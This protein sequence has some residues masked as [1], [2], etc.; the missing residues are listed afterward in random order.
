MTAISAQDTAVARR[1]VL[2]R[3]LRLA[4][5]DLR[6]GIAGFY[7][8]V[9]CIA[10]GVG[11]IAAV[12]SLAQAFESTLANEGAV[13]LGGDLDVAVMHRRA[14]PEERASLAAWGEVSEAATLHGM[15]GRDRTGRQILVDIKAVDDVYPLYGDMEL[16]GGKVLADALKDSGDSATGHPDRAGSA[17]IGESLAAALQV[18]P[19]DDFMIGDVWLRVAAIIAHEPD[20]MPI[21]LSFGP[22]V[23]IS[24]AALAN[25]RLDA[26]GSLI[27]W[28]YRLKLKPG[29]AP[30][31]FRKE[32]EKPLAAAGFGVR[33]RTDPSPGVRRAIERL[34]SFLTLAGLT[35]LLTGGVGVANGVSAFIERKRQVIAVYKALGASTRLVSASIFWQILLLTAGAIMLGLAIGM[36]APLFTVW[37]AGPD[38]PFNMDTGFHPQV[39]LMASLYGLLTALIFVLWPLGRATEIRAA[40]LLREKLNGGASWPPR[41]YLAGCLLSAGGLAYIAI[42]LASDPIIALWVCA[43]L[44][45]AFAVFYGAG[46]AIRYGARLLPRPHSPEAALALGNVSRPGGLTRVMALSLGAG[47]TILTANALTGASLTHEFAAGMPAKAPNFFF[48]LNKA[49]LGEFTSLTGSTAPG[50]QL[51]TAPM[52]RGRIVEL[53]GKPVEKMNVPER[54]AWVLEG[55]RGLTFAAEPAPDTRIVAGQWWAPDYS[56]PPQVSFDADTGQALGLKVGDSVTVNVLGRNVT[57]TIAN[58]RAIKWDTLGINFVMIFSPDTLREAPYQVLASLQWPGEHSAADESRLADAV[59]AKFPSATVIRVREMLET[60]GRMTGYVLNATQ[61]AG[62]VTL[63]AGVIVLAGALA[64]AQRRRIYEAVILKTLGATRG[65]IIAA[66]LLEQISIAAAVSLLASVCGALAAWAVC[67]LLLKVPFT[68]S[69]TKLLQAALLTAIF[70]LG[71]GTVGTMRILRAKVAPYLRTE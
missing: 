1:A 64:A 65:R 14:T 70:V 51:K 30:E 26:P 32:M 13:L 11:A 56:G 47:L 16:A 46:E 19:G 33:D 53:A 23:L 4:W 54:A 50:S 67:S 59:T 38:L 49:D 39:A 37:L 6:G 43:G 62:S 12:K 35:A 17:V 58:F 52:L 10:L 44:A 48:L 24:H 71:F 18:K 45:I 15:A 34:N 8:F 28:H 27:R 42:G 60:A 69:T 66:Q 25:T 57:A 41:L 9:A 55:D 63:F 36:P 21:S 68:F 29:V 2:P 7:V 5:R 31:Q 3:S 22:R 20:R 61:A 40:E